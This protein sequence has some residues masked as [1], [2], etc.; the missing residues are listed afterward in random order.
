MKY[1]SRSLGPVT[2]WFNTTNYVTPPNG[3]IRIDSRLLQL[4]RGFNLYNRTF[5]SSAADNPNRNSRPRNPRH[6]QRNRQAPGSIA[7]QTADPQRAA[8]AARLSAPNT[9]TPVVSSSAP[10]PAVATTP[11]VSRPSSP[12]LKP[13]FSTIK[14]EDFAQKGQISKDQLKNIPFEYATEVQA[15]TLGHILAGKDVLARA[16]TGTGKTLAFLVPAIE[17]LRRVEQASTLGVA[18]VLVIS[19]T[20]ELA[21]QI[22]Q[23]AQM[24]VK[25]MPYGVQVDHIQNFSMRSQLSH[26]RFLILDEADRLLDQ[27]FRRDLETILQALP[28]RKIRPRTVAENESSTHEHVQ[29]EYIVVEDDTDLMP[30]VGRLI[31]ERG[32]VICFLPTARATGLMAEVMDNVLSCPVYSIHSRMSQP[33]RTKATE[34]FKLAP[35]GVLFSSDVTARGI[36]IPGVTCVIQAGLPANI[37]RLGRTARAGNEGHGILVLSKWEQFFLSKKDVLTAGLDKNLTPHADAEL[38]N[39]AGPGSMLDDM[40]ARVKSALVR[41]DEKTKEQAWIG[42]YKS[43]LRDLGWKDVELVHRANDMARDVF[44]YPGYQASDNPVSTWVPPPILAKT[45]GMMG[46]REVRKHNLF[47]VQSDIRQD[48]GRRGKGASS[49]RNQGQGPGLG[50]GEAKPLP[51]SVEF[52][53]PLPENQRPFS[54]FRGRGGGRGRELVIPRAI[55]PLHSYKPYDECRLHTFCWGNQTQKVQN[56][57]YGCRKPKAFLVHANL[58]NGTCGMCPQRSRVIRGNNNARPISLFLPVGGAKHTFRLDDVMCDGNNWGTT[59]QHS[60]YNYN[61]CVGKRSK[62]PVL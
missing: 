38:I 39:R 35:T 28:D 12:A 42:Y 52:Q 4:A 18:S 6:R 23:E 20:R 60:V 3:H 57:S 2:R 43:S 59:R 29:Q 58:P 54:S 61:R 31:E 14:F 33:R 21:Q 25:G 27:G 5:M 44:L 9:E 1:V 15:K 37:H 19:P 8:L 41:T 47:N 36:D 53:A 40:R 62:K 26:I 16:K 34:D 10:T 50:E 32:K 51:E 46:L 55:F 30:V 45:I 11:T 17:T 24:L 7:Q 48:S 49:A 22:G 13:N 56:R